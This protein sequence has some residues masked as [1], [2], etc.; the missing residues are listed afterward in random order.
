[1]SR[2]KGT[3]FDLA[4]DLR[5]RFSEVAYKIPVSSRIQCGVIHQ[6]AS[7]LRTLGPVHAATWGVSQELVGE[8]LYG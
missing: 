1:M 2:R 5:G 7:A 6:A 3:I 8:V 4:L